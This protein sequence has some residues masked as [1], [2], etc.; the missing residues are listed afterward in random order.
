M[1]SSECFFRVP[2]RDRFFSRPWFGDLYCRHAV[3]PGFLPGVCFSLRIGMWSGSTSSILWER[4][5]AFF[6]ETHDIIVYFDTR[7]YVCSSSYSWLWRRS[8]PRHLGCRHRA[9]RTQ[10]R[11]VIFICDFVPS[12]APEVFCI[13]LFVS[14]TTY[15]A[16]L[17]TRPS[18]VYSGTVVYSPRAYCSTHSCF[19]C[20]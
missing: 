6:V 8:L 11:A 13:P 20:P 12:C 1:I 3:S 7:F 17:C 18:G 2:D 19:F 4:A 5:R 14:Y 16:V 10:H 15:Y 9:T